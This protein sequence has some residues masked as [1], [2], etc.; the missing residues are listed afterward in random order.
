MMTRDNLISLAKQVAKATPNAPVAYSFNDK[1]Y[2][3][4][5]LNETL[6]TELREYASTYSLYRENKNLIFAL[7]EEAID[8]VLPRRVA[9]VYGQFAEVK[10]FSQGDKPVFVQ[11]VTATARARAK[12]FIT[13]VGLAGIYEVFKL[14]GQAIEVPTTA[15]GGAAQIGLEEFL[16]GTVDFNVILEIVME[17][18]DDAIYKEIANALVAATN[19]LQAK[20]IHTASSFEE[21]EMDR[22]VSIVEAYGPAT[23]Y[24]TREFAATMVPADAWVSDNM[25]DQRWN[26]GHLLNYKGAKVVILPQSYTDET[27]AEKVIDPAY[28]YIMPGE[29][30]PILVAME[31]DTIVDEFVNYDRSREVQVY[32][33]IGVAARFMNNICVYKNSALKTK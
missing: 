15:F 21:S 1:N 24:C 26:N 5:D 4:Q 22:L 6:R 17:G 20:N 27:N 11:K 28:A 2:S 25:R 7:I 16:D 32:K 3:Y 8:A 29:E 23:I 9:E 31:G 14:D 18:L 12:K 13:R 19:T 30:K 33:K 10:T